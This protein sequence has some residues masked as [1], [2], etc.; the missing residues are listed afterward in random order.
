[1][2]KAPLAL[3]PVLG[4][5]GLL[6]LMDSF[7]L[8][9]LRAVARS[10]AAGGV[11]ALACARVNEALIMGLGLPHDAVSRYLAP[12]A[13]EA[14]KAAWV[15]YLVDRRRIGFLVDAAI[16]GFAVGAGFSL[17]ENVEYLT[18]LPRAPLLL[19]V[20]RGLGTA[21][22]HG[23]TTSIMA[24]ASKGLAD[25]HP[26]RRFAV[27]V[28]GWAAAAAIHS[29][30][31]HFVL[32]PLVATAALLVVLPLVLLFVFERSEA[33]TREWLGTGFDTDVEVL[34]LIAS[35][36][37]AE[38]RVG[39]YLRSLRSRFPGLVVADMLCLLRLQLE[40]SL[41]AKGLLMAREAGVPM[42]I[43][44][45]VRA[46]FDELRYLER[47]I[48]RTGLLALKPVLSRNSRDLW[49]LYV[50]EQASGGERSL[51]RGGGNTA[52]EP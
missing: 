41:R 14:L 43:G 36:E 9:P 34:R 28:P 45:D 11:A 38:T 23:A 22:L 7:K 35:P 18:A 48:G 32:P 19:W 5:L 30:Y 12:L 8:V 37:G 1:L 4:F 26:G 31:N 27:F 40:L 17:V 50:L 47:S 44:R 33:R 24:V 6:V 39:S 42:P 21:V 29:L 10:I 13:E 3:L 15:V 2:A 25:R 46:A 16:H 49:E 51:R 52:V 20:V